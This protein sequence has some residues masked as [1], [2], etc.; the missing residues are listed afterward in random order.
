MDEDKFAALL[1]HAA[2]KVWSELPRDAQEMLFAAAVNDGVIA[3]TLAVY[4][5]DRHPR[6]AHPPKP[7]A[8]A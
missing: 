6:T 8:L 4:L 2:L 5:H 1:G 7:T 3:N